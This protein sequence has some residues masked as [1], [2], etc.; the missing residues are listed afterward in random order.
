MLF[1]AY[2]VIAIAA[3]VMVYF[4]HLQGTSQFYTS[5]L[6]A[7]IVLYCV[8]LDIKKRREKKAEENKKNGKSVKK[9]QHSGK[10]SNTNI[11][12]NARRSTKNIKESGANSNIP[13]KSYQLSHSLQARSHCQCQVG[14]HKAAKNAA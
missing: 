4:G 5:I 7:T 13:V 14:V 8:Y 12:Q 1:I 10:K 11:S 3:L 6:G 2:I 9:T